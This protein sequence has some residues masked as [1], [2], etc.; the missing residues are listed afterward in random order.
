MIKLRLVFKILIL[1]TPIL[2]HAQ[3]AWTYYFNNNVNSNYFYNKNGISKNGNYV[4]LTRTLFSNNTGTYNSNFQIIN[5]QNGNLII[6][7][8]DNQNQFSGIININNSPIGTG[9]I[10]GQNY[11]PATLFSSDVYQFISN[12]GVTN[13]RS[14]NDSTGRIYDLKTL[15]DTLFSLAEDSIICIKIFDSL[16]NKIGII[17]I[18]TNS[19]SQKFTPSSFDFGPNG[20]IVYGQKTFN[21][22]FNSLY[23]IRYISYQS[24]LIFEYLSNPSSSVD[25]ITGISIAS[26]SIYYSGKTNV[27]NGVNSITIGELDF[28]GI[29][30]WDTTMVYLSATREVTNFSSINGYLHF[31]LTG[32]NTN[33]NKFSTML[34]SLNESNN[35]IIPLAEFDSLKY[36]TDVKLSNNGNRT[37][38]CINANNNF[39]SNFKLIELHPTSYNYFYQFHDSLLS[40]LNYL[41]SNNNCVYFGGSEFISKFDLSIL[42]TN[43]PSNIKSINVFPNPANNETSI[44][45]DGE[46]ECFK[47]QIINLN[48]ETL[49]TGFTK[50]GILNLSNLA[51]GLYNLV[52]YIRNNQFT[53]KILICH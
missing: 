32:F 18:D 38:A 21:N 48:G 36:A 43:Q 25:E 4:L 33:L 39:I 46:Q 15:N 37:F 31:G 6:D 47:Y 23:C 29:L 24:N 2:S 49:E 53:K 35:Q 10:I 27:V 9:F 30:L 16:G 28:N 11:N 42:S 22:T 44:K 40:S 13:T 17:P 5:E 26:N 7:T 51:N 20:I 41:I 1:F 50:D 19:L 3:T 14:S 8:T 45:I 52:I 12:N 34:F